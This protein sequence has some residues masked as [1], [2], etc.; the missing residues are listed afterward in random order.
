[1]R[2]GPVL[3]NDLS[4]FAELVKFS[5]PGK[6]GTTET[7]R[8]E[9]KTQQV[10][11][12]VKPAKLQCSFVAENS[13]PHTQCLDHAVQVSGKEQGKSRAR[14][15]RSTNRQSRQCGQWLPTNRAGRPWRRPARRACIPAGRRLQRPVA[16]PPTFQELP[17]TTRS[18]SPEHRGTSTAP[19]LFAH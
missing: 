19:L 5:P 6:S 18:P 14:H 1:S 11:Q 10:P 3:G 17:A 4:A 9:H 13:P 12:R 7:F 16:S 8:P 2:C 15:R